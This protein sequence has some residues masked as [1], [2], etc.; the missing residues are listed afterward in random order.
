MAKPARASAPKKPPAR[1]ARSLAVVP[2]DPAELLRQYVDELGSLE[3]AAV[4]MRPMLKRIETL[5]DL[6]RERFENKDA[7]KS[8]EARGAAWGAAL[9]PRAYRSTVDYAGLRK[10][11]GL[12]AY[13]AIATPTLADLE[14]TLAPD[15]FARFVR[16][17]YTGA[18]PVKTF[19]I[20][21]PNGLKSPQRAQHSSV[22]HVR[23]TAKVR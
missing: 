5:K 20:A 12:A 15:V 17:A 19:E 8:F 4:E 21:N 7:Q 14:K 22:T 13:S 18:R 23:N 10:H 1:A 3:C 6:I 11:M 16:Y 2:S 9:G